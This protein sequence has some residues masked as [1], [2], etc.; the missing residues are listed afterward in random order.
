MNN[1]DIVTEQCVVAQ[2]GSTRDAIRAMKSN[3][4]RKA[5][6]LMKAGKRTK[7]TSKFEEAK[8]LLKRVR[9]EI[10]STRTWPISWLIGNSLIGVVYSWSTTENAIDEDALYPD[11]AFVAKMNQYANAI[12]HIGNLIP[13]VDVATSAAQ[14][15]LDISRF[16]SNK[17]HQPR[18]AAKFFNRICALFIQ[19]VD[20]YIDSC[21]KYMDDIKA[22]NMS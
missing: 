11:K 17:Q 13:G 6:I 7:D 10:S 4:F 14:F 5:I 2:E 18:E 9:K 3:D 19:I 8:V 1:F 12:A 16:F 15:I 20:L 21:D 22:E